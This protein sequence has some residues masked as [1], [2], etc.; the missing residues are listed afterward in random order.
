MLDPQQK[1][2]GTTYTTTVA[3][4]SV[5]FVFIPAALAFSRPFGY[6]SLSVAIVCS[7]LCLTFAWLNWKKSSQ[8]T[9]DSI[10]VEEGKTK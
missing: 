2:T 3:L 8:L 10:E 1:P 6:L 4:L 7:A 9:I 5:A